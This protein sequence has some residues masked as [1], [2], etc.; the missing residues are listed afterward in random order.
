MTCAGCAEFLHNHCHGSSDDEPVPDD[1]VNVAFCSS[2]Q[3]EELR[4]TQKEVRSR[5]DGLVLLLKNYRPPKTA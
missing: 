5:A 3:V 1:C 4:K 2:D